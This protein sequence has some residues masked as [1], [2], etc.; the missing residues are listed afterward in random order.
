MGK[1]QS[2][3]TDKGNSD[4]WCKS[5]GGDALGADHAKH[6]TLRD[7]KLI[8]QNNWTLQQTKRNMKYILLKLRSTQKDLEIN[9]GIIQDTLENIGDIIQ[10]KVAEATG[11]KYQPK[12]N[13]KHRPA[14]LISAVK[15]HP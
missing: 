11:Q 7:Y 3:F 9:Q 8:L 1:G 6:V 13:T 4:K 14:G 10:K 5:C 2:Y 15:M 12:P